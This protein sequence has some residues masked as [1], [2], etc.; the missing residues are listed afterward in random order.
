MSRGPAPNG[1]PRTNGR[2][3]LLTPQRAEMILEAMRVGNY[4]HVCCEYAGVSRA[5][6]YGW[7]QRARDAK[8]MAEEHGVAIPETEQVYVHFLDDVTQ[9]RAQAEIRL[10]ANVAKA[11]TEDWR[12][13]VEILKRGFRENWRDEATIKHAGSVDIKADESLANLEKVAQIMLESSPNGA[14]ANGD[15]AG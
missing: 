11:A 10:V 4:F 7:L 8:A 5:T 13:G 6:G 3:S 9:A 15:G 12:A 1:K 2:P 14:V